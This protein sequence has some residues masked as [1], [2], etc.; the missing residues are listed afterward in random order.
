MSLRQGETLP[1]QDIASD[2]E[3]RH[4]IV[5]TSNYTTYQWRYCF[6]FVQYMVAEIVVFDYYM[7]LVNALLFHIPNS[8]AF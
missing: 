6:I 2:S 7:L 4:A 8:L 5:A 1:N 3:S